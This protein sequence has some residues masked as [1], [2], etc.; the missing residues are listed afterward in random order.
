MCKQQNEKSLAA[1]KL[2][3]R[4]LLYFGFPDIIFTSTDK[5]LRKNP[6]NPTF[7]I[8]PFRPGLQCFICHSA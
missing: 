8:N 5:H 6:G 3:L 7:L 4:K 1:K 2:L